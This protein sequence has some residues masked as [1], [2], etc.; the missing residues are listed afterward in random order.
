MQENRLEFTY[1]E[2]FAFILR[3]FPSYTACIRTEKGYCAIQWKESSTTSPDPFGILGTTAPAPIPAAGSSLCVNGFVAIPDLSMDGI[4]GIPVPLGT[5]GFQSI[6]C[7]V[8]FGVEGHTA[9]ALI[10]K[11]RS[12][13]FFSV[14]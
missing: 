14:T 9:A 6:M 4:N 10:S 3:A 12:I 13:Q 7:G 2:I 1:L 5:L 11:G 8:N